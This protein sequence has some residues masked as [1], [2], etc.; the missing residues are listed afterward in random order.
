MKKD[1]E[2]G[3]FTETAFI[4]CIMDRECAENDRQLVARATVLAGQARNDETLCQ[5]SLAK[6]QPFSQGV[7]LELPI[8]GETPADIFRTLADIAAAAQDIRGTYEMIGYGA[9]ITMPAIVTKGA[10]P[11]SA[12]TPLP[13]VVHVDNWEGENMY[14]VLAPAYI[15]PEEVSEEVLRLTKLYDFDS[16]RI[17]QELRAA[18]FGDVESVVVDLNQPDAEDDVSPAAVH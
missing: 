18:G 1:P 10:P 9:Y 11:A 8:A 3:M 2:T 4:T 16:N 12:A 6:Q 15:T 5:F 7:V 14:L 17:L 13:K